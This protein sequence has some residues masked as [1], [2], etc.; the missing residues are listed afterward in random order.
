VTATDMTEI[1]VEDQPFGIS[2]LD[3]PSQLELF[4]Q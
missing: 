4:S 2:V 1:R 3:Q